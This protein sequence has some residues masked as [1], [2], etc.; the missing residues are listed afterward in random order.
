MAAGPAANCDVLFVLPWMNAGG[1]ERWFT[2]LANGLTDRG[3]RVWAFVLH[4]DA[5]HFR[6]LF[7]RYLL[8]GPLLE[9]YED[10]ASYIAAYMDLTKPKAVVFHGK[11]TATAAESYHGGA[12][13]VGC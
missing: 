8:C 4:K 5:G 9:H 13:H 1:G 3:H 11:G 6:Q 10:A 2:T 7:D 12:H